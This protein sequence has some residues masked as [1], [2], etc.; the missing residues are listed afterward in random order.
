MGKVVTIHM[1]Y[2]IWGII[3]KNPKQFLFIMEQSVKVY[4]YIFP[5]FLYLSGGNFSQKKLEE[6]IDK[7]NLIQKENYSKYDLIATVFN[8]NKGKVE[9][10]SCQDKE[11]DKVKE[12]ILASANFPF[13]YP[14]KMKELDKKKSTYYDGGIGDNTPIK[15]LY[16]KGYRDFYVIYLINQG[17]LEKVIDRKKK[18]FHGRKFTIFILMMILNL[19]FLLRLRLIKKILEN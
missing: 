5:I 16:D 15:P 7:F 14:A 6:L 13:V 2:I 12:I 4:K 1:L 3:N 17:K 9:Y 19:V 8:T 10:H 18:N 11:P